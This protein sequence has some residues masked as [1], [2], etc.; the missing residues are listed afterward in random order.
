MKKIIFSAV[1]LL[2]LLGCDNEMDR[3]CWRFSIIESTTIGQR[4]THIL[5]KKDTCNLTEVEAERI[6]ISLES[7]K[8]T[9]SSGNVSVTRETTCSK[10]ERNTDHQCTNH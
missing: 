7:P 2:S 5:A 6:R 4:T 8:R 1:M 9:Y 10:H 3:K